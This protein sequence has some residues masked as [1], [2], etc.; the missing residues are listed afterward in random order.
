MVEH[1]AGAYLPKKGKSIFLN[2]LM[3]ISP[4]CD[5]YPH[6]D[7]PIVKDIG[8]VGASDPVAIDTASCDLVNGE[9]SIPGSAI[10][11]P[12][13]KGE[14]KFRV[15]FP[16]IDWNIQLDHARWLNMGERVYT[17]VKV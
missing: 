10:K 16:R 14:D 6:N 9:E 12:S 2:F 15:V 1:A 4:N 3:Q 8:M 7:L 11:H 13:P 5:C 17:L